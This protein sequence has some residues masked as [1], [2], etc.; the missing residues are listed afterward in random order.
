MKACGPSYIQM[1]IDTDFFLKFRYVLLLVFVSL[2]LHFQPNIS[3]VE[4]PAHAQ[5][6]SLLHLRDPAYEWAEN[7]D[8][9]NI[10]LVS[11]AGTYSSS[12]ISNIIRQ[13]TCVLTYLQFKSFV[14]RYQISK[15]RTSAAFK[16]FR[17]SQSLVFNFYNPISW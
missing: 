9:R 7:N 13:M 6:S 17:S 3:A 10:V 2:K 4:I 11:L 1:G 8:I 5:I 15:I 12:C 16:S 14:D